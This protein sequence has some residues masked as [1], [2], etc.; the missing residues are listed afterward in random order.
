MKFGTVDDIPACGQ[1]WQWSTPIGMPVGDSAETSIHQS[2][3]LALSVWETVEYTVS[4]VFSAFMEANPGAAERVFGVLDGIK[5]KQG[6]LEQA[7]QASFRERNV[8]QRERDAW[9]K[10]T[11][12]YSQAQDR[13]NEIAHGQ[14]GLI[15]ASVGDLGYFLMP[16]Y[17]AKKAIPVWDSPP[18]TPLSTGGYIY[19]SAD[20]GRW[21]EK[22]MHLAAWTRVFEEEYSEKYPR[23]R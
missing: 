15:R 9:K 23:R 19:T 12:H 14:A 13:R 10:L 11:A 1:F 16:R 18:G 21:T 3:G 17:N 5:V 7:A 8:E 6:V 22:F 20:I 2:V 4:Q